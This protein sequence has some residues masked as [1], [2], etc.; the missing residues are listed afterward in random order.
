MNVNTKIQPIS[1]LRQ[2]NNPSIL[3][4][5]GFTSAERI[6]G[7][8]IQGWLLEMNFLTPITPADCMVCAGARGAKNAEYH[9]ENYYDPYRA[10]IPL[11]DSCHT[12]LHN[13]F[14][15]ESLWS[16]TL[17]L[18]KQD[19][20]VW[21]DRLSHSKEDD[22][23][24]LMRRAYGLEVQTGTLFIPNRD[25]FPHSQQHSLTE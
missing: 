8:Q 24:A 15:K 13:R 12:Q 25:H 7:W 17:L 16:D 4:Y 9:L 23:A 1:K 5:N 19:L 11:C 22:L 3:S 10:G 21:T 14:T 6:R 20:D 18:Y 2:W